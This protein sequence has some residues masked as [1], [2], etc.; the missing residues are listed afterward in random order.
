[1]EANTDLLA[2][3]SDRSILAVAR[4]VNAAFS[5][6]PL[7]Q[8]LRP[9]A[10][11][12]AYQDATSQKWQFRR[13]QNVMLEGIVLHSATVNQMANEY[14][15]RNKPIELLDGVVSPK[16]SYEVSVSEDTAIPVDQKEDAGA[17]AFLIPPDGH[18]PWSVSLIWLACKLWLLELFNPVKDES[19]RDKVR[20]H[21]SSV[22]YNIGADA[23]F[24]IASGATHGQTHIR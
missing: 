22:S 8:W 13:V 19:C 20:S 6:D 10:T 14:P 1:L 5:S 18:L 24:R 23:N 17:V 21:F 7:I 15:R 4:T 2:N 9:G 11:P 3:N 16:K 12:W